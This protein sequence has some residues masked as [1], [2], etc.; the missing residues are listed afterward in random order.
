LTGRYLT[1]SMTASGLACV[2]DLLN[3]FGQIIPHY[4]IVEK[5]GR[6]RVGVVYEAP[7]VKIDRFVALKFLPEDVALKRLIQ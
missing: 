1:P 4:R 6:G 3:L 7:D 2:V 5:F